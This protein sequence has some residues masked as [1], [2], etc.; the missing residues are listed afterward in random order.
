M[1]TLARWNPFREFAPYAAFPEVDA[2]FGEPLFKRMPVGFE[3]MP[4]MKVDVV[5]NA[6]GYMVKADIPGMKKE[7]I[8]VS[9]DGNVVTIDAEVR[10]DHEEKEGDKVL[11]SERYFGAMARRVML[12]MDVD[13]AKAEATY[14][15]GV[16]TLTL[17]RMP[18]VA[19][20]RLP[21]H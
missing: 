9:I 19:S 10:R 13:A 3:P 4:M 11:R 20:A 8:G 21:V 14:D 16:L 5:E 1:K 12:P 18:G 17:P 6:T 15:G 7:D 2:L